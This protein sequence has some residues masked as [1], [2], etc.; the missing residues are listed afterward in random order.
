[1]DLLS[2]PDRQIIAY[3]LDLWANFIQTGELTMSAQDAER[4]GEPIKALSTDQMKMVIRL[5]DLAA[6]ARKGKQR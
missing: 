3:A 4:A 1:M 2:L 6:K 5:R